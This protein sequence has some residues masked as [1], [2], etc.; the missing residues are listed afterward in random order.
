MVVVQETCYLC[1]VAAAVK[2]HVVI[3]VYNEQPTLLELVRRDRAWNDE[4]ARKQL[5]K[6]FEALGPTHPLTVSGR[7]RLS[8]L[9]FA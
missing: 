3:P 2:L 4:E 1:A 5:L 7:R 8:S 9:L 6:L